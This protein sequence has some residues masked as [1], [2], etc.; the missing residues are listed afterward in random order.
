MPT[1]EGYEVIAARLEGAIREAVAHLNGRLDTLT[2]LHDSGKEATARAHVRLDQL[3]ARI[4]QN[5]VL[6]LSGL[7]F[8]LAVG[9]FFFVLS[10]A[11]G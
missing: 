9:A 5:F 11:A 8:P 3:E 4:R 6:A 1:D 10:R 7:L 2:A